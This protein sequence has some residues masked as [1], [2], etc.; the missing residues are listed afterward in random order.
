MPLA[1][2]M[3]PVNLLSPAERE[4]GKSETALPASTIKFTEV[5]GSFTIHTPKLALIKLTGLSLGLRNR[6][7]REPRQLHGCLQERALAP[8]RA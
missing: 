1:A 3:W 6:L 7:H 2:V 8:K 5:L 4:Q